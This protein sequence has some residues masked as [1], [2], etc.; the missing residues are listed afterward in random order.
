VKLNQRLRF[1]F[2]ELFAGF[3]NVQIQMIG[4]AFLLLFTVI[5]NTMDLSYI[6]PAAHCDL[7]LE[8]SDEGLLYSMGYFGEL[9]QIR[10][11]SLPTT[12][13]FF[14]RD[15]LGILCW[16]PWRHERPP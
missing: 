11:S 13:T 16:I 4:V 2:I 14:R 3:G 7:V 10:L 9:N 8:K 5:S 12:S 15:D 6:T 1:L